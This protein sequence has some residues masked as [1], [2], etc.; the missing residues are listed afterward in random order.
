VDVW[1][2]SVIL[3]YNICSSFKKPEHSGVL[4]IRIILP[5]IFRKWDGVAWTGFICLRI[6]TGGGLL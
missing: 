4:D 2:S 5:W 3:K 1:W 6:G